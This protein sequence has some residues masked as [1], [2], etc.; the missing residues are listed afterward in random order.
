[1][2]HLKEEQMLYQHY[3][4]LIQI[5]YQ[6]GIPVFSQFAGLNDMELCILKRSVKLSAFCQKKQV[7]I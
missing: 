1:M 5:S 2:H 7:A 6:R 3:N 4:D